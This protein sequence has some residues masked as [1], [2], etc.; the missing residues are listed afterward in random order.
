MNSAPVGGGAGEVG[1]GG[2]RGGGGGKCPDGWGPAAHTGSL[3]LHASSFFFL[4]PFSF[5]HSADCDAFE[6]RSPSFFHTSINKHKRAE[7]TCNLPLTL[8]LLFTRSLHTHTHT[9]LD[10]AGPPRCFLP[11]F[12][13]FSSSPPGLRPLEEQFHTVLLPLSNSFHCLLDS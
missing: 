8:Q 4:L 13:L 3:S 6:R 5:F 1:V 2:G 7:P 10:A 12:L 11:F 9:G